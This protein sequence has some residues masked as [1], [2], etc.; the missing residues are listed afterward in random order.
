MRSAGR[1]ELH[2][3]WLLLEEDANAFIDAAQTSDVLR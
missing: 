3:V 1:G 2:W